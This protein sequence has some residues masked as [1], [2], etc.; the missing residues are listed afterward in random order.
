[1][2]SLV[3]FAHP[4]PT[5]LTATSAQRIADRLRS[6]GNTVELADLSAEGFDPRHTRADLELLQ[7]VGPVPA[8]VQ[9]EQK[10]VER[11]DSIVLVHPVYWWGMPG[12]LKGWLD[13]VLTFGWAFGGESATA[14]A[15]RDVHLVAF[16]GNSPET[17][18]A[19]G[20]REAIRTNIEHGVFEFAG[21]PVA[22]SRIIHSAADGITERVAEA[23]E[24]V[25]ADMLNVRAPLPVE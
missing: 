22:S 12:L 9:R 14:L 24:A 13:R 10:R 20:Y 23:I 15:D 19:H 18:D 7:G 3:I 11:A 2:H 6:A 17:Y 8:D 21:G 16:G 25:T 5:S 1:M 4:D